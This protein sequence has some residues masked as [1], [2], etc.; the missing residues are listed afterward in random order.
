M[1]A[2]ATQQAALLNTSAVGATCTAVVVHYR[3]AEDTLACIASLRQ[4]AER[5][6]IVVID[7]Q[8]PDNSWPGLAAQ[9][10][11]HNDVT[12]LQSKRND[13][14]GAGCNQGIE[15]ALKQWPTAKH[16]LLIN[17]D[18]TLTAEALGK[19][20]A[21]ANDHPLAGIVGCR[22]DDAAGQAWFQNGRFPRWTLSGF[23]RPPP[24]TSQ[25]ETEFVTGACM[26]VTCDLLH[27][28][29]R[30]DET[31]FLYCEDADLCGEVLARGRQLWITQEARATH[32]GGGSQPGEHVLNELSA[33]RLFWLTR[34]KV[35]LARK[36]LNFV[37]RWTFLAIAIGCKPIAGLWLS[38][39]TRF[40]WPYLRGLASGL[41]AKRG[42]K[43]T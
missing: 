32:R 28:G 12:L 20:V 8:S 5:P 24:A 2:T 38:R 36:R 42:N 17:P 13:G 39:S 43:A 10:R 26:L 27:A 6:G 14:F 25:H 23:H 9:L 31:F 22:I 16:L 18:A 37:Q 29:L 3:N 1:P 34:A 19:M 40:L 41:V 33:E 4:Q 15:I 7:N 30:F 35:L 11:A 21:T